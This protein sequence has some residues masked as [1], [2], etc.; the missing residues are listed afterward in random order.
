[1]EIK[2]IESAV[3]VVLF[4]LIRLIASKVIDRTI[5]TSMLEKAR[6]KIIKK[7]INILNLVISLLI[8][9]LIW[10]VD[11]SEL[12]QFLSY[13]IT[14]VGVALFAQWSI[15]SNITAS[16]IIFFF[17]PVKLEDRISIYDKDYELEGKISDIGLFF[18]KIKSSNGEI[19]TIPNNVFLQKMIKKNNHE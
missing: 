12:I 2:L 7:A 17:H 19:T 1:M 13:G 18:T 9:L 16:I 5:E 15:L 10:G 14:V 6:G 8:L 3:I 4:I 11:Q